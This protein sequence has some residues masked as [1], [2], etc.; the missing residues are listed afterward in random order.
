MFMYETALQ[1]AKA[2]GETAKVRRYDRGLK[3]S[4]TTA[5]ESCTAKGRNC[6]FDI[7]QYCFNLV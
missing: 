4:E 7:L 3:V 6:I 5:G 2:A 1:N